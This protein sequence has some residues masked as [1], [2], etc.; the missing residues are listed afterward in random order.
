MPS[1]AAVPAWVAATTPIELAMSSKVVAE[2]RAVVL[3]DAAEG[4]L[5]DSGTVSPE[6]VERIA[7]ALVLRRLVAE[8]GSIEALLELAEEA[9]SQLNDFLLGQR[10][11]RVDA[12]AMSNARRLSSIG[13]VLAQRGQMLA[14]GH[15]EDVGARASKLAERCS[16]LLFSM[17]ERLRRCCTELRD[18]SSSSIGCGFGRSCRPAQS[19]PSRSGRAVWPLPTRLLG[20][21]E[22]QFFVFVKLEVFRPS[23]RRS[24]VIAQVIAMDP[25]KGFV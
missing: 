8:D 17:H 16:S 9:G 11:P 23:I 7:R 22:T 12:G 5:L 14:V 18:P 19:P 3:Q 24:R 25:S 4:S 1:A 15:H 13:P 10:D 2:F 20:L 21:L 6:S